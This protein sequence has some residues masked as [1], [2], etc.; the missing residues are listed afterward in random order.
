MD[1][2]EDCPEN[3]ICLFCSQDCNECELEEF[4]G[5]FDLDCPI[6]SCKYFDE[7]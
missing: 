2:W 5:M 1:E 4:E 6:L 7:E 3:C